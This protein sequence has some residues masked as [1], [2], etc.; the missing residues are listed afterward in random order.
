[1]R[2][3]GGPTGIA[4]ATLGRARR[5]PVALLLV[6]LVLALFVILALGG[7]RARLRDPAPTVLVRTTDGTFVDEIADTTAEGVGYWPV[8]PVP[9]RVAAA[10]LALED[11]RFRSHPG[12]DPRAVGRALVQDLRARRVV[13][14]ASTIAMQVARMQDPAARTPTNKLV[15]ATTALLLTARY[16]R[17]AV[18]EQYLRHAPYGNGIHGIGYAARRYLDKPLADLSW[19]ETAFLCA[20]PQAPSTTNPV[21]PEGRVRA[22]ARGQ[23]ILDVLAGQGLLDGVELAGA[24]DELEHLQFPDRGARPR[25]ALHAVLRMRSDVR[26]GRAEDAEMGPMATSTLDLALQRRLAALVN[27]RVAEWEARGAGNA[28]VLVVDLATGAV[29]AHV[30]STDYFGEAHAGAIDYTRVRRNAGSTLKPL[31]YAAALDRGVITA[32]SVL[33]DRVRSPEGVENADGLGLGPLLPRQALGNSRNVAAVEVLRRVGPNAAFGFLHTLGL[34]DATASADTYGEGLAIGGLP[35]TLEGLVSAYTALARDGRMTP[36]TWIEGGALHADV[37]VYSAAAARQVSRWLADPMARLPSFP[38]LGATEL[39]F[40]AAVKTGTSSD[41]RDAWAVGYTARVL[42][43]VWVG[44]PGNTPMAR[45]SGYA[46][47]AEILHAVLLDVH[48]EEADG[49]SDHAFPAPDGHAPARVCVRSGGLATDR[50]GLAFTEH[51]APGSAPVTRCPVHEGVAPS[52]VVNGASPLM[53]RTAWVRVVSPVDGIQIHRDPDA[54]AELSTLALEA[55]VDVPGPD[56]R[57]VWYVDG[58]PIAV[59]GAPF[60]ARWAIVPGPHRIHA[61]VAWSAVVSPPVGVWVR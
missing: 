42:V 51:F 41:Y 28:A 2:S 21:R 59:A 50:C 9:P 11:R 10:T 54:P 3:R 30:G 8:T 5:S 22:R 60:S 19:A 53:A 58:E 39:P 23:R 46:A 35:V 38:R 44:D 6:G 20:L 4:T 34:H 14:G 1:M 12:V 31:L 24:R 57:V 36:L 32:A 15:E 26:V 16:G 33:D 27:T 49:Y 37:S 40:A 25:E 56:T 13:S 52:G 48:S 55:R 29:R 45:L 61:Q 18:L 47:A 7:R 17:D 43:G